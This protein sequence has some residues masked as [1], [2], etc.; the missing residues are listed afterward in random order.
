MVSFSSG[1]F[2]KV[3]VYWWA[4]FEPDIEVKKE[5][6]GYY[7]PTRV[8]SK[9]LATIYWV[10]KSIYLNKRIRAKQNATYKS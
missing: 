1:V 7:I 6:K 3:L 9:F 8:V 2:G 4:T 10:P 5:K